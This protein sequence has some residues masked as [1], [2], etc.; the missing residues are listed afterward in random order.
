MDVQNINIFLEALISVLEELGVENIKKTG[1]TKKEVMN[2]DMDITALIGF[3]G[4][5]KGNVAYSF[6]SETG[7]K[8]IATKRH[9]EIKH[10]DE[11]E[12]GVMEQIVEMITDRA[13]DLFTK[14]GKDFNTTHPSIV[15]GKNM[16]FIISSVDTIS[17]DLETS[18][19]KIQVNIGL[20]M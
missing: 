10:I 20:E 1:I 3:T 6:G 7:K 4:A 19:G 9:R 12:R 17:V 16:A 2:V 18:F 15:F 11:K 8:L 5:I 14:A 13:A